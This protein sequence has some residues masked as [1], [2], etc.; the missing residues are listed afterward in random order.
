MVIVRDGNETKEEKIKKFPGLDFP[1]GPVVK[2]LCYQCVPG[3]RGSIPDQGPQS[4]HALRRGQKI[5]LKRRKK[6]KKPPEYNPKPLILQK[7][8]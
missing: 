5:F 2:T 7:S 6:E 4:T 8:S 1:G 3:G